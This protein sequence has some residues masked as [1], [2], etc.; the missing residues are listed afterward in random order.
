MFII[1]QS[2]LIEEISLQQKK[3]VQHKRTHTIY[4][5]SIHAAIPGRRLKTATAPQL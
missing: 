2:G 4:L 5:E 3:E 1:R